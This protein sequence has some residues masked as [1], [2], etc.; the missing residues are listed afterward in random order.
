MGI[1]RKRIPKVRR[2]KRLQPEADIQCAFMDHVRFVALTHPILKCIFHI[3][4]GGKRSISEAALFK[5]MGVSAGVPDMFVAKATKQ[6]GGLFLEF[7]APRTKKIIEGALTN[8]K[9]EQKV[10]R[11]RLLENGYAYVVC[12]SWTE[13]WNHVVAYLQLPLSLLIHKNTAQE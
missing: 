10:W 7:K 9:P 13:A 12:Y 1:I 5:H 3:P 6:Y 8:L 11:G 4:N 2:P